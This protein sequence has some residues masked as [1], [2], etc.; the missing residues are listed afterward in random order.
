[1]AFPWS[2][3]APAQTPHMHMLCERLLRLEDV[4][5]GP[6]Q[7]LP[8]YKEIDMLAIPSRVE[9][10][11]DAVDAVRWCDWLCTALAVQTHSVHCPPHPTARGDTWRA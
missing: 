9:S 1:M 8:R 5:P 4:D 2:T 10:R 11:A 6:R 7:A 3:A